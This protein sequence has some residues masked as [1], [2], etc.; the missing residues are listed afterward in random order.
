MPRVLLVLC[1]TV[2]VVGC[3]AGP[4]YGVRVPADRADFGQARQYMLDNMTDNRSDRDYML[5]RMRLIIAALADGYNEHAA[6]V[7]EDVYALLRTQGINDDKTVLSV[8]MNEDV[9]FWKGEPFEQALALHYVGLHHA[10][11]GRWGNVRAAA[12]NARFFLRDFGDDPQ[13]NEMDAAELIVTAQEQDV[14]VDQLKYEARPSNFTAA[15]LMGAIANQILSLDT[16]ARELY[17]QTLVLRPELADIVQQ[18][19]TGQFNTLLVVDF[20]RGPEKIGTGPDQAIAQF[21]PRTSSGEQR[22]LVNIDGNDLPP[23][24]WAS[25]INTMATDLMWNNLEDIRVAKSLVGTALMV[26]GV[27]VADAADND[28]QTLIGIGLILGGLVVRS[29]AHADTRHNELLP[30]RIY[31]V[32]ATMPIGADSRVQMMVEGDP[33][34]Q[35]VLPAL[36]GPAGPTDVAVHYVKLPSDPILDTWQTSEL[37]QYANEYRKPIEA[38]ENYPYILGGR[39]VMPPTE[40]ALWLY[41]RDGH[42]LGLT[43]TQFRELF[44]AEGIRWASDRAAGIPGKHVLEGGRY[45]VSPSPGSLGE[46]RLLGQAHGPYVPRSDLVRQMRARLA[47]Q[48]EAETSDADA[49]IDPDEPEPIIIPADTPGTSERSE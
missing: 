44:Q 23:A 48:A 39:S 15:F 45:L 34:S 7:I 11:G 2:G 26:S 40:R 20:G 30:Q 33:T 18:L 29:Q 6:P 41:Q 47:K 1:V 5:D 32:P 21:I 9:K 14:E 31:I 10:L 17:D 8:V 22:L 24:T 27:L 46:K 16:Q 12:D 25:D 13:G 4:N 42:L 37:L 49:L 28:T 3:V 38:R 35:L 19:Q 36:P 43:L